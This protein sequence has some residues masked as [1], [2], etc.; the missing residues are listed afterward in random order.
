MAKVSVIINTVDRAPDLKR[1]LDSVY[2]QSYR[3]FEVVVVNNGVG[4][5]SRDLLEREGI[6]FQESGLPFKVVED[7]TKKLSYLFNLGWKSSNPKTSLLAYLADDTE[8]DPLWLESAVNY[9]ESHA[10]AGAVSGPM[11]STSNP[12]G[13]MNYLYDLAKKNIF[14]RLFLRFYE[15]FVMEGRTFDPGHLCESGAFT[16]GAGILQPSIKEPVEIDLLTSGN[17]IVRREVM[18]KVNGFDEHFL[19]NHADGDL[20]IRMKMAGFQMIFH[21]KVSVLHH[22]R[23]GPTRYPQILGRDTAFYYLKDVRPCSFRGWVGAFTNIAVFKTYFIFKAIQTKKLNQL[24]G[25]TGFI[26]GIFDF[27]RSGTK[28]SINL[29]SKL[30]VVLGFLWLV[31]FIHR[32]VGNWGMLA[33]GD[34]TP[35]PEN[36]QQAFQ[37]FFSSFDPRSPGINMPQAS[38]ILSTLVPLEAALAAIF[39]GGFIWAQR[40]YHFL[41]I[42]LSFVTIYF[43]VS[44]F[45]KSKLAAFVTAIIYSGNHFMVAEFAGGFEG[46]LYIPALLPLLIYLLYQLY[47]KSS[48][49]QHL[50]RDL[51]IYSVLLAFSYVLS[52]HVLILLVPFWLIFILFPIFSRAEKPLKLVF[53]NISILAASFLIV[54]SVSAYHAYSY[55]KIALPFLSGGTVNSDLIPFFVKNVNDTYWQM[56]LPNILRLGGAYFMNF[57]AG[58]N[59]WARAGFVIPLLA[60]CWPIF[61][62]NRRG[63]RLKVGLFFTTFSLLV[64]IFIYLTA[65]GLTIPLFTSIPALF[66]FRN[67]SRL[68]LFLAF[69]YSPLIALTLDRLFGVFSGSLKRK[70]VLTAFVYSTLLIISSAALVFYLKGFFSGDFTMSKNR[71]DGFWIKERQYAMSKYLKKQQN[72]SGPFR[73]AH[74]PWNHEDAEIKLFW[75][76]PYSLGVPIE[77]GAY[78]RNDYLDYLKTVYQMVSDNKLVG[79]GDLLSEGAVKYIVLDFESKEFGR[80]QYSFAYHVPWLAGSYDDLTRIISGSPDV[81]LVADVSGYK[82]YENLKFNKSAINVKKAGFYMDNRELEDKIRIGLIVYTSFS[83]IILIIIYFKPQLVLGRF[84]VRE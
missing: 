37:F 49:K 21:P 18:E 10:Q 24:R 64:I 69:L 72:L 34:A 19:F 32:K 29:A 36:Y 60:L 7:K 57:Y 30:L 33:Y 28:E 74:F 6:K 39:G 75:L 53:R 1:C 17:M 41:P 31:Y 59:L 14:T 3:D 65:R 51:L 67:P 68:S 4:Q 42:P 5:D 54:L 82:I 46:N 55:F 48:Q 77:Y 12:P 35:F 13:E 66:R 71:G 2:L 80:A 8:A 47:L 22:M 58:S 81:K 50:I 16:M 43:F 11:I 73:A 62:E 70:Q 79:F 27:F 26:R 84:R 45:T 9:L 25:I 20:F 63:R 44:K 56:S 23:F 15:Y 78:I 76:D 61:S 38:V 52:D 83:W 40:I